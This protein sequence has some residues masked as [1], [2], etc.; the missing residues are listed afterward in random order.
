[1]LRTKEV[2]RPEE[3]PPRSFLACWIG[4]LHPSRQLQPLVRSFLLPSSLWL[5]CL[6]GLPVGGSASEAPH[7][8]GEPWEEVPRPPRLR[9]P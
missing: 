1:M 9:S 3:L 5:Q 8:S 4:H 6:M 7:R 2:R